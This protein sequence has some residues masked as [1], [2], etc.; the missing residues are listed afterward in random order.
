MKTLKSFG[1]KDPLEQESALYWV[2]EFRKILKTKLHA[3]TKLAQFEEFCRKED[4][5]YRVRVKY[6]SAESEQECKKVHKAT[7]RMLNRMKRFEGCLNED[8]ENDWTTI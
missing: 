7:A 5:A 4:E 3:K 2:A 1:L 6:S 8:A